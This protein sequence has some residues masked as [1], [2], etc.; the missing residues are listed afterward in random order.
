M[1]IVAIGNNYNNGLVDFII[2]VKLPIPVLALG[3]E[4]GFEY[5]VQSISCDQ[6]PL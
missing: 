5:A 1:I 4:H 3:W 6:M 2:N